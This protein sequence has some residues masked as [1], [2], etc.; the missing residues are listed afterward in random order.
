[1]DLGSNPNLA[2]VKK[3]K[4]KRKINPRKIVYMFHIKDD[5][6]HIV[7]HASKEIRRKYLIVRAYL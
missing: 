1:M 7:A 2:N 6:I 4:Q 5:N 3:A